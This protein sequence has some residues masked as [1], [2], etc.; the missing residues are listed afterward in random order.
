[1]SILSLEYGCGCPLV[2]NVYP[3]LKWLDEILEY[4]PGVKV[5]HPYLGHA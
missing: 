5:R 2:L 4:C 1:M 3:A